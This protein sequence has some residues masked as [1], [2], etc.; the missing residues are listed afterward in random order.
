MGIMYIFEALYVIFADILLPTVDTISDF[1][2]FV[3]LLLHEI[4]PEEMH[5]H[6]IGR[7]DS[8][9]GWAVAVL[10]PILLYIGF[11]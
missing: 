4:S 6:S 7:F 8:P 9:A 1:F 2:L 11:T 10:T 5:V 3:N